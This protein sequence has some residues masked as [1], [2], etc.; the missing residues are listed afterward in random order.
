MILCLFMEVKA[1][2]A[3]M[4]PSLEELRYLV[5]AMH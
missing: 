3:L 1:K 5:M 2:Q 4:N